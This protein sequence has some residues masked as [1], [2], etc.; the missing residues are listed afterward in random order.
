MEGRVLE[1]QAPYSDL[2]AASP[3]AYLTHPTPLASP[4]HPP[5]PGRLAP[6]PPTPGRPRCPVCRHLVVDVREF[7]AALPNVLHSQGFYLTPMTLEVCGAGVHCWRRGAIGCVRVAPTCKC[8]CVCSC[9]TQLQ[10]I[11]IDCTH[12]D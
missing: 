6:H 2:S 8:C 10:A 7:G 5:T 4:P 12:W 9:V 1:R 11:G 3:P